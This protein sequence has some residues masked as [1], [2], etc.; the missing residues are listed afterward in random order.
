M[1]K[2]ED[3]FIKNVGVKIR[4]LRKKKNLTQLDLADKSDLD[5][6][7]IQR[8]EYGV[9]AP[10]LKTL[11]KVIRGLGMSFDDFFKFDSE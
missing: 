11:Y 9:S 8:L 2:E 1:E 5:E 3:L 4:E 6:R 7:Q 10:T